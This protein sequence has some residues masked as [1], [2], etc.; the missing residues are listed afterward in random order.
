MKNTPSV[1]YNCNQCCD[2]E[3]C[4]CDQVPFDES[5]IIPSSAKKDFTKIII[6]VIII[7]ATSAVLY[8]IR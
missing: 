3:R 6:S 4:Y 8:F 5:E 2:E 7:L 1:C